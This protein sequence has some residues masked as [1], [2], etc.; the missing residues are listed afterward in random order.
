MHPYVDF[1]PLRLHGIAG[2]Y[3][4]HA[5]VRDWFEQMREL[6]HHHRI[7]LTEVSA[8]S[9]GKLIAAGTLRGADPD[10]P[11]SFW[12]L[13]RFEGGM[14]VTARHFLSDRFHLR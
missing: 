13:E 2:S 4:G 14:I 12:A 9:D 8:S 5:G 6:E 11:S 7:E 3:H 10:S 1:H